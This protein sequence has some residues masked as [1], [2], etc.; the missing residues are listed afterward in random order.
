MH[1]V[2]PSRLHTLWAYF[3]LHS[4]L[5]VCVTNFTRQI[6]KSFFYL[7]AAYSASSTSLLYKPQVAVR[8]ATKSS[9]IRC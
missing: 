9:D 5:Y 1:S 8:L 7:V 2:Y 3:A 4:Y 6:D